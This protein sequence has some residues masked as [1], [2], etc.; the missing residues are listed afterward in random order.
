MMNEQND[1]QPAPGATLPLE[2]VS[3]PV[4]A[5]IGTLEIPLSAVGNLQSGYLFELPAS[6]EHAV[7]QLYT[8]TRRVGSGRLVAIGERLGVRLVEWKGDGH[9]PA[10]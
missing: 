6:V 2:E 3:V 10:A 4:T 9:G 7:V 1:M 8:G 5:V